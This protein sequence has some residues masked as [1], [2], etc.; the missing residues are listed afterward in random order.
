M[1]KSLSS[2]KRLPAL[3]VDL[4]KVLSRLKPDVVHAGPIQSAAFLAALS[5][6]QPLVSMSWGSD[7]LVDADRTRWMNWVTRYTLRR[8]KV[9]VGDCQAVRRKAQALGFAGERVAL[10]PWG[11]DLKH[12]TPGPANDLRSR[13]G[14]E[15]AFVLLSLRSWE[16]IYGVDVLVRAFARAALQIPELRLLLLGGGSQ[17]AMLRR[18]LAQNNL[19]ERV[20]F[21]GHV[22]QESLP[23]FYQAAD[24]YLSASHSDGSS[25]SLMEALASGLPGLVSDIPGNQEW[26]VPGVQGWLFPDGNEDALVEGIL[27]AYRQRSRLAELGKA[28]RRL[29]EQRAD[30]TENF[31]GLLKAYDLATRMGIK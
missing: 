7:L 1:G 6:F 17:A 12:F 30:W 29:A 26:I 15:E 8:T 21:G 16:P 13:L 18:L 25:V 23:H 14:W 27:Q 31:K 9:L 20:Y 19:N 24:V 2:G 10:F 5:G 4:R 11:V 22:T 3:W 28:S